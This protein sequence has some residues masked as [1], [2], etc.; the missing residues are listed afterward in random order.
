MENL[1][2]PAPMLGYGTRLKSCEQLQSLRRSPFAGE[3]QVLSINLEACGRITCRSTSAQSTLCAVTAGSVKMVPSATAF[4]NAK[5]ATSTVFTTSGSGQRSLDTTH[6]IHR[7]SRPWKV[8][9]IGRIRKISTEEARQNEA[10]RLLETGHHFELPGMLEPC[11]QDQRCNYGVGRL[12]VPYLYY[13][14][15][16][17][18]LGSLQ[19]AESH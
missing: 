9:I 13:H 19:K 2:P 14:P 11:R 16:R 3:I 18:A 5:T 6:R 12:V 4:V 15:P 17:P 1:W 7:K 10:T 8:A